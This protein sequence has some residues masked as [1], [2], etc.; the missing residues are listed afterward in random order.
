MSLPRILAVQHRPAREHDRRH[1]ARR[2]THQ[3]R[4]RGL[5]AA[6]HQH[7]AVDRV[8]ADRLLDVHGREIAEQHRGRAEI[9][10]A[11]RE[12]RELEREAAGLVDAA[13]DPL[14]Q[15]A[16]VGVARGELGERVADPDHRATVEQVGRETLILHPAAV[17]EAVPVG[18][19]EPG[20]AAQRF[21]EVRHLARAPR[22]LS[23]GR[24]CHSA[25]QLMTLQRHRAYRRTRSTPRPQTAAVTSCRRGP[26]RFGCSR[27]NS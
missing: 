25:P 8:A 18:M 2:G 9:A 13:L 23:C 7:H 12:H 22:R 11:V 19:A 1:V 4:R 5:V 27:H 26:K 17:Q 15:L 21:V 20:G 6:G 14:R 24:R 16:E 10:L 3:Q